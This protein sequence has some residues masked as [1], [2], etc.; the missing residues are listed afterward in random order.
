M[1]TPP[2]A[3]PTMAPT[4]PRKP[5]S[6]AAAGSSSAV[7]SR[8]VMASSAGRWNPLTADISADTTNTRATLGRG[9]SAFTA[10]SNDPTE[11]RSS[12]KVSSRRRSMASA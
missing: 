5:P 8:G 10:R 3:G 9:A 6:A 1:H 4:L 7:T 2:S 11:R 12:A